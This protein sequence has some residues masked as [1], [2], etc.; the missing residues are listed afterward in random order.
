VVRRDRVWCSLELIAKVYFKVYC[1]LNLSS[2]GV[3]K[4]VP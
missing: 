2:L 4:V 3:V 1:V